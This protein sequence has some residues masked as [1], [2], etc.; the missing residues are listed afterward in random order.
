MLQQ[1]QS[2][3]AQF[4]ARNQAQAAQ[5]QPT[6]TTSAREQLFSERR[7]DDVLQSTEALMTHNREEQEQLSNR[8]LELARTLK[9]SSLQFSSSLEAEKDVMSRAEG[10]LDKSAQGMD[11]AEKK[12]GML[13]RMSEG[14]GWLGRLK[15]YGMIAGLWLACFL[16]VFVGPK[17]RF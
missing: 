4:K 10:S 8:L 9:E 1:R 17:L 14:Q 6:A 2:R 12:M 3:V 13:R 7:Q 11:Q 5:T 15:L 16:L